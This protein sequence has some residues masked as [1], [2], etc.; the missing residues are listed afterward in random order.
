LTKFDSSELRAAFASFMT[1]VTIVTTLDQNGKPLGFT[2]NSFTSVSLDPPLLLVCPGRHL[3]SYEVF[4]K[5]SRFVVSILS[6]GQEQVSNI[7][8]GSRDDRFEQ[9]E[10]SKDHAGYPVISGASAVFSC[11]TYK[12]E[13]AGD[14]LVLIGEIDAVATSGTRGLGYCNSGY[15][16]LGKERQ[17]EAQAKAGRQAI[18]AAII[19]DEGRICVAET[20]GGIEILKI[21]QTGGEGARTA[22]QRY[23]GSIGAEVSIGPVYSVYDDAAS[24]EHFTIFRASL[25]SGSS[26]IP[27]NWIDVALLPTQNFATPAL[28]RML[29]RYA[30]E[31]QNRMFGLYVGD[32]EH[33][34][35]H[36]DKA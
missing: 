26:A 11:A 34:E 2:A 9:V 24:G 21:A 10:W 13:E 19:E 25:N 3:S 35:I 22:L 27:G 29:T 8:A 17:A 12:A 20:K 15:F 1:G 23:Y 28:Q 7:F 16:S 6:E 4:K 5:A 30:D 36:M 32:S 33:G 31:Y 14:H 18:A